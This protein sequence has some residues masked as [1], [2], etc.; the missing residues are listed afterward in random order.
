MLIIVKQYARKINEGLKKER[1]DRKEKRKITERLLKMSLVGR[2]VKKCVMGMDEV[3][4]L[5]LNA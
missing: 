3:R 1:G 2:G 5:L 4:L